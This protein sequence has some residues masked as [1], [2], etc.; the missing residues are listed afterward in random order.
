V[1]WI[2]LAVVCALFLAMSYVP[3]DV[4]VDPKYHDDDD[5]HPI[6]PPY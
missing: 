2:I 5:D 6:F 1:I 3:N 4:G